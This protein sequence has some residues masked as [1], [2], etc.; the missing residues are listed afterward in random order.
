LN[1]KLKAELM[2]AIILAVSLSL[3][4]VYVDKSR[5]G[6]SSVDVYLRNARSFDSAVQG[7]SS[8]SIQQVISENIQGELRKGEFETTVQDVKTLVANYSGRIPS[9][10]MGYEN[11][12]WSGTFD[13]RLPT[14]NVTSFTFDLRKLVNDHGKVTHISIVVNEVEVNQ[15]QTPETSLS[16]ISIYLLEKTEGASPFLD[17]LGS[18]VL[19]LTTS[20][21]WIAEGL[22]VGV[23][24]CFVSLG[25]VIMVN[26][27]I[28]PVWK[29]QF[30]NK[31][32]AKDKSESVSS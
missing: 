1:R 27:G 8:S 17:Q 4:A 3:L 23:P 26:R 15:T 5:N 24:L 12:L 30:R 7:T 32:L 2:L 19:P 13:C 11:E 20:L 9:L 18:I 29:K 21:V 10:H 28:L 14:D 6:E 16:E 31:S 25:V 22:F